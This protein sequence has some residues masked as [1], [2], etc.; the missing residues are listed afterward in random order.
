MAIKL[1][2]LAQDQLRLC[3]TCTNENSTKTEQLI[4]QNNAFAIAND[5]TATKTSR[6]TLT[7]LLDAIVNAT[8]GTGEIQNVT[9]VGGSDVS[10]SV[11]DIQFI[12]IYAY[13]PPTYKEHHLHQAIKNAPFR[14]ISNSAQ[15]GRFALIL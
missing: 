1:T 6:F 8:N 4:K 3:K 2:Q 7:G 10:V 5:T 11:R 12:R 9:D 14:K 13:K 15:C